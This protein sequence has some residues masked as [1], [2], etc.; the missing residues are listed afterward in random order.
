MYV[1][2]CSVQINLIKTPKVMYVYFCS[3]PINLIKTLY[4]HVIL[5]FFLWQ[6]TNI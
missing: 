5:I 4:L 2:F 3:V 1:Y 6:Y